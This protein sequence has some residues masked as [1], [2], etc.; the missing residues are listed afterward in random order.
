MTGFWNTV[1][2]KWIGGVLSVATIGLCV[3]I[4]TH[5]FEFWEVQAAVRTLVEEGETSKK[6]QKTMIDLMG[7]LKEQMEQVM[8]K[9]DKM[10]GLI[11]TPD[12]VGRATIGTFGSDT[13]YVEINEY[14]KAAMYLSVAEISF[15]YRDRDGIPHTVTLPVRGSFLNRADIGHLVMLS[16]KAGRDLSVNGIE[17]QITV[18]EVGK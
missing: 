1:I 14:G 13:A 11:L 17:R 3:G 10:E 2:G 8:E 7:D 6:N 15:T 4:V 16:A 18:G 5:L 9:Q 12:V